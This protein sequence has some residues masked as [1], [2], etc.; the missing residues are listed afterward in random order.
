[1]RARRAVL[2]LT[3]VLLVLSLAAPAHGALQSVSG[4]PDPAIDGVA[5]GGPKED[6]AYSLANG[7]PLWYQDAAG[8]KLELCLDQRVAVDPAVIPAGSFLPCLT[9]EPF[10]AA[11]ISFPINFGAEAFWWMAVAFAPFTSADNGAQLF[12]DALIVMSQ[13]ASFQNLL[14]VDG[15][16]ASFARLRIRVNV[17]VPGTYLVTHPYGQVTY[18]VGAVGAAREIDQTQD[19]G[20]VRPLDPLVVLVP[21]A[22]APPRGDFT[23][24]LADGPPPVLPVGFDPA[25][26]AGIVSDVAVGIGPFLVPAS[27]PGGVPLAPITALDGARYLTDPGT[28]LVPIEVPVVGSPT[29]NNFLRVLLTDPPAGFTLNAAAG[30]QEIVLDRFQVTGKI[31]DDGPNVAP[32]ATPD[33]AATA[34]GAP[35]TID[36]VAN[37]LDAV[38]AGNVHGL[39]PQALGLP[40]NDPSDLAG[41]ILLARPLTTASGGTVR[42]SSVFQTG[43]TTFIY[44]PAEGFSGVDTFEYVVQDTGGLISAPA[45]VTIVVEDLTVT[46]AEYR[47]RTGKW[48]ISGTTSDRAANSVTLLGG[49]RATLTGQLA[50]PL[51]GVAPVDPASGSW[52]FTSRSGAS[53][54]GEPASVGAISANGVRVLGAPLRI[55]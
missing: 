1:M 42:R 18:V 6:V 24:A 26:D 50:E 43:K 25:S 33:L 47:P 36:V 17:P 32:V 49:P 20:N 53:P 2:Q 22:G 38:G 45:T 37:D 28:D 30:S 44:T 23:L 46:S 29:G 7:F 10:P 11:R 4:T 12:G 31:F 39:N 3:A 27:A 54:G 52:S 35:V 16:Q 5:P 51:I 41:T 13:E 34:K 14:L 48:R 21:P 9:A 55:R 19:V 40:S 8:L 15:D